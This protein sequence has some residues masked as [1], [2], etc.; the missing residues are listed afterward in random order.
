[1]DLGVNPAGEE[2]RS[3]TFFIGEVTLEQIESGQ[4][5]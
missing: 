4:K 5:S 1:L 3:N 2:F